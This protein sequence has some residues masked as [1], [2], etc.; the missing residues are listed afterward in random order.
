M[1]K[2]TTNNNGIINESK[3]TNR[4]N[5]DLGKVSKIKNHIDETIQSM[6]TAKN[7]MSTTRRSKDNH[8]TVKRRFKFTSKKKRKRQKKHNLRSGIKTSI[9]KKSMNSSKEDGQNSIIKDLSDLYDNDV[10]PIDKDKG[11]KN[12]RIYYIN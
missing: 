2:L 10:E 5:R 9:I 12:S 11:S 6:N 8:T 7:M 3:A 4:A 1:N